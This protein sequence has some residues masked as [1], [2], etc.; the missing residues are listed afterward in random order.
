MSKKVVI[1]GGVAGGATA[2][3]RLRR[4]DESLKLVL[5]ERGE[6]VSFANCGLPYYIGG[7]IKARDS[8]LVETVQNMTSKFNAK[9]KVNSEV[10]AILKEEKNVIVKNLKTNEMYKESY[11]YLI[12]STGS[13]PLRPP[14][15]G[16]DSPNI[17]SLWNIPDTDIIKDYI[18]DKKPKSAVVVGG[19]FIGIEMAENLHKLGLEVSIVEMLDQVMAPID[20]EMAEIVHEH[21]KDKGISLKLGDGVKD[22]EY[23]DE[24]V[25]VNLNSSKSIE[26]DMVILSIGVRPNGELAKEANLK[27]NQ[28]GGIVV[29][30]QLRTSDEYIYAVGDV[31]EVEDFIFKTQTMVPLAG[32]ANKQARIVAGNIVGEIKEYTGTQ[33]TS[34]AKVFDLTVANTGASEK[35]LNR[36]GKQYKKDYDIAIVQ[37]NS[38][39]DYYPGSGQMTLKMIYELNGKILGAQIVGTKGVDKRI[40]VLATAIRFNGTVNDLTQLELAYA[41]PYSA[42]KDPVNMLGFVAENQMTKKI[43]SILPREIKDL[44]KDYMFLDIM[45]DG[46]RNASKD[47]ISKSV[48]I[49][50]G[51]L[52]SNLSKLDKDITYITYCAIGIRGYIA[53][54]I[55]SQNG[56][57]TKNLAG[58]LKLY[59][60]M[61]C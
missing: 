55:L 25:T 23:S 58:G 20:F 52:R 14:I 3:A 15:S 4:L 60:T 36:L 22:F 40:D 39:A 8:L 1:I 2:L 33:G 46:E 47:C 44:G 26:T 7:E 28:R 5:F 51:Q 49:P 6:Y 13:T 43:D 29:D 32:P 35:A 45:E 59:K 34:I 48:H 10:I 11:D 50:L 17:F 24:I 31:I 57:K 27:V 16:I 41:P 37:A 30:K 18:D 56:F 21:L 12:V 53:S 38:N 61:Y 42:A 54:R 9:I 19:G